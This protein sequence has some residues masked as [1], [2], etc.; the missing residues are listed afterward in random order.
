MG[1]GLRG[2]EDPIFF[3]VLHHVTIKANCITATSQGCL[4]V[5]N[6]RQLEYLFNNIRDRIADP[7]NVGLPSQSVSNIKFMT[8]SWIPI[9]VATFYWHWLSLIPSCVTDH[10]HGKLWDGIIYSFLN[11]NGCT[12][13]VSEWISNFIPRF[14]MDVI[15][16]PCWD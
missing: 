4:G 2:L 15:T 14:I 13:E 3:R 12:V 7:V 8:S 9:P 5:P 1:G 16:F 11:F 10:I 6:H